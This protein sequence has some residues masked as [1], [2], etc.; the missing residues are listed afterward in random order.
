MDE[1]LVISDA[2]TLMWIGLG[3]GL[4]TYKCQSVSWKSMNTKQVGLVVSEKCTCPNP[5]LQACLL[6]I[7]RERK[8][9]LA[10]LGK[11]HN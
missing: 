2:L 3:Y 4:E 1:L 9:P 8:F 6:K 11:Q 7:V 5:I 10:P